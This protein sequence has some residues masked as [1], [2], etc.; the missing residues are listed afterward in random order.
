[1]MLYQHQQDVILTSCACWDIPGKNILK[2]QL[3][4]HEF[5]F[6]FRKF[7]QF[8]DSPAFGVNTTPDVLGMV[9]VGDPVYA[10]R[11]K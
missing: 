4:V 6:R 10:I 9:S 3:H 5:D 7:E 11:K 8:A 2:D 1:M